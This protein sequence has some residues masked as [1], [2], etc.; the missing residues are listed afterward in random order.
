[1]RKDAPGDRQTV[2]IHAPT[3]GATRH[4][5]GGDA[6]EGFNS[7]AHGGRDSFF[8]GFCCNRGFQFTRP[9]GGATLPRARTRAE[10]SFNSRAHGGR[11]RTRRRGGGVRRVSIHAP[12]GGATPARDSS[13]THAAFQFTRPR[14]ARQVL[15]V[16]TL[17]LGR[18]NSRAH[19]GRD[20]RHP[21]RDRVVVVSIHAPTGGATSR[22][23]ATATSRR[24][25]FTR[26]RGARPG[27]LAV[28]E[29]ILVSIH[30]PTG[31][32]TQQ[33]AASRR[34]G[35]FQFTRPRG[36]RP[37]AAAIGWSRFRFNSRAHGG[38]DIV[39]APLGIGEAVSIH[40]PT[41]GAT[42]REGL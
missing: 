32:A 25:Q 9:R 16:A 5:G 19:G 40:A 23:S 28:E 3:G 36:A 21:H 22:R 13:M 17:H 37:D 10:H 30:A 34:M 6:G 29:G 11:D 39:R 31:G 12:T 14:G 8:C 33:S 1:M 38:R 24:F 20:I 41:G 7:R 15:R 18:F 4:R 27:G 35:A 42:D 26:P 2:S